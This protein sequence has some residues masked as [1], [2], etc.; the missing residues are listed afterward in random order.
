MKWYKVVD[1]IFIQTLHCNQTALSALG[2][3]E[4][5]VNMI[6]IYITSKNIFQY[7]F[8]LKYMQMTERKLYFCLCKCI[9][10]LSFLPLGKCE[11][12]M[13]MLWIFYF[14][15]SDTPQI[16]MEKNGFSNGYFFSKIYGEVLK[17]LL[18]VTVSSNHC[19]VKKV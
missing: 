6:H 2:F 17:L 9:Y 7:I 4:N 3:P 18:T 1:D 12:L 16:I 11:R 15:L 5:L 8:A 13:K 19:Q 10:F 14:E